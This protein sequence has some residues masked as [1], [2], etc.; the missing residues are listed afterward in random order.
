[1]KD[2]KMND[3]TSNK[4][5]LLHITTEENA[6]NIKKERKMHSSIHNVKKHSI[7]WLGDGV[8][9]WDGNDP[10]AKKHGKNMVK[11]R[12]PKEKLVGL[13]GILEIDANH[14]IDLEEK[15]WNLSFVNFSKK[16][17]YLVG[18]SLCNLLDSIKNVDV[19]DSNT[20]YRIGVLMGKVVNLYIKMLTEK[21]N[22]VVDA[23]SCYFYHGK[24]GLFYFSRGD[25]NI[26]QFCIKNDKLISDNIDKMDIDYNI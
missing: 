8:Y 18:D 13:S 4:Y 21:K 26:K 25:I 9:F 17:E 11:K 12:Y 24:S 2:E 10:K 23:F 3:L 15:K 20:L 14:H 1:M 5:L 7:Q 22:K 6:I 19:V 16:T